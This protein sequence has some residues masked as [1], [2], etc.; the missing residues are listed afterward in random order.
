MDEMERIKRRLDRERRARLEA[1]TLLEEKSRSLYDTT[2]ELRALADKLAAREARTRAILD[3]A[4]E[5]IISTDS[6]GFIVSFNAAASVVFQYEAGEAIG[7]SLRD[8]IPLVAD[9]EMHSSDEKKTQAGRLVVAQAIEC[10][11]RRSD[12]SDVPLSISGSCFRVGQS[13]MCTWVV[14]DITRV[15]KAEAELQRTQAKLLQS[16]KLASIGQLAAGVAHEINNPLGFVFSNLNS[17]AG[18][19]RDIKQVFQAYEQL[20]AAAAE[21]NYTQLKQRCESVQAILKDTDFRYVLEDLNDLINESIDGAERVREIVADLRDFSHVDSAGLAVEN[22]NDL[23][24]KTINIA[25]NIL[26]YKAEV[27]CDLRKIPD[28]RCYGGKLGQAFL[29]LL[30]NAA[31]AIEEKGTIRVRSGQTEDRVWVE[32]EDDGCGIPEEDLNRIFD[33]FFTTKDVGSGTGLGLNVVYNIVQVHNGSINVQSIV[34]TGTT[35]RIELPVDGPE[36][37]QE[38]GHGRGTRSGSAGA[39]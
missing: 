12:G 35:F 7:R 21:E 38:S 3:T 34:G 6:H 17:L 16:D 31:Q 15:K 14:R 37:V 24:R 9:Y 2:V 1:E 29:N 11:G 18:Y 39:V 4:A 32:V 23:I 13:T 30:V 25:S 28:I 8:L 36:E 20:A 33:P 22:V 19:A 5:G 10:T 26:K 27:E